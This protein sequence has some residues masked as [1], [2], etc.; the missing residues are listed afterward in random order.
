MGH[1]IDENGLRIDP[2]RC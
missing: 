1:I 2:E